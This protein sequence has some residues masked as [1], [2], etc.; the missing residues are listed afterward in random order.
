MKNLFNNAIKLLLLKFF[1]LYAMIKLTVL[2]AMVTISLKLN[3]LNR[4]A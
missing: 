4:G 3:T 1:I 2:T